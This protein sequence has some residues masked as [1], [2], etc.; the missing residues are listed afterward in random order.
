MPTIEGFSVKNYGVLKDITMGR[1]ISDTFQQPLTQ[2]LAVIGKNGTGKSTLFDAFGFLGDCLKS[3][4]EEACNGN[5]RRGYQSIISKGSNGPIEFEITYRETSNNRPMSYNLS[6]AANDSGR[7]YIQYERLRQ[8][9]KGQKRGRPYSFLSITNGT[10][11]AWVGEMLEGDENAVDIPIRLSDQNMPV[12]S[13]L[14]AFKEHPRIIQFRNFVQGWYLCY[15]EPNDARDLP[16]AGPQKH[17]NKTGSNLSNVLQYMEQLKGKKQIQAILDGITK[18]VPGINKIYTQPT[19]DNRLLLC[20][21]ETGFSE[22]HY[23]Q[24]MSDGTIKLVAY[25]VLLE[26]PEMAPFVCLEEPENGLYHNLLTI[27]AKELKD[28]IESSK[29]KSQLFVTTHSPYFINALSPNEVWILEKE[30]TGFSTIRRVSDMQLV[31]NLAKEIPL[32]DLWYS[33]Y[34]ERR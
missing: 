31:E 13:T 18:K 21:D 17:L 7:P 5:N 34:L 16:L 27:L 28:K 10:G 8:R 24:R 4:V 30:N 26:D 25:L 11:R 6:I 23:A 32:G 2:L 15:F 14:G 22:P 33:N 20:F 29:S 12:I 9:R 1:V 3:G 19:P